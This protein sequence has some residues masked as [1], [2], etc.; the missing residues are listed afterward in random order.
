MFKKLGEK[1]VKNKIYPKLDN[2]I[3]NLFWIKEWMIKKFKIQN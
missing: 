2:G 3:L 1:F